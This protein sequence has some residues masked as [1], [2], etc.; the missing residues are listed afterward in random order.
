M[1]NIRFKKAIENKVVDAA[2]V[3]A[4]TSCRSCAFLF[5]KSRTRFNLTMDDY[6][7]LKNFIKRA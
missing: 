2:R 1:N 7:N 4:K 6:E 3:V 5:G